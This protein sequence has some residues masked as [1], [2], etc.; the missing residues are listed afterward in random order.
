MLEEQVVA[1]SSKIFGANIRELKFLR[2][3]VRR[4]TLGGKR[5]ANVV[6]SAEDMTSVFGIFE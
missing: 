1:R 6:I 4:K 3:P 5:V 2:N